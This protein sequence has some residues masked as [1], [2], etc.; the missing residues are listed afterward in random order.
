MKRI[1]ATFAISALTATAFAQI[2]TKE[3]MA[4]ADQLT[5]QAAAA[6]NSGNWKEAVEL[7]KKEIDDRIAQKHA[8]DLIG[9]AY[10][11]QSQN[12]AAGH[13]FDTAI[14]HVN[15]ALTYYMKGQKRKNL[16]SAAYN[17]SAYYYYLRALPGDLDNAISHAE[18]SLKYSDNNVSYVN[19]A[20]QL[21]VYYAD[22][23]RMDDAQKLSKNIFKQGKKAYGDKNVQ[24]AAVLTNQ[25]QVFMRSNNIAQA[26]EYS[27]EAASIYKA[28]G[29]T[30]NVNYATL[31]MSTGTFYSTQEQYET[32]A[33]LLERSRNLLAKTEGE[34]GPNYLKC[35]GHLS[36]AYSN[37]GNLEKSNNIATEM[38][39]ALS[40][41]SGTGDQTVSNALA[42]LNQANV[43]AASGNFQQAIATA[44]PALQ[45]YENFNDEI[46]KANTLSTLAGYY[47]S[48]NQSAKAIE[49]CQ[50]SIDILSNHSG[51]FSELARSYNNMALAQR[52]SGNTS[53]A[54]E[55]AQKSVQNYDAA[56]DTLSTLYCKSLSNLSLFHYENG[57]TAEAIKYVQRCLDIQQKILGK[58]H[59]DNVMPL[60]NLAI[61][62]YQL[63]ENEMMQKYYHEAFTLQSNIVRANF[64]HFSTS[65]RETYWN[66]KKYLYNTSSV[67]ACNS[68]ASDSIIMND[69]YNAQL[70]T[71][72]LLLN[73]EIDFRTLLTRSS[74]AS[75]LEKYNSLAALNRR[76]EECYGT[77]TVEDAAEAERL[78]REYITLERELIRDSKEY[79]DFT[80]NMNI[81]TVDIA[82]H[83]QDGEVAL[84]LF[85]V[86][87]A[88]GGKTFF[89]MYL[90][91]GWTAP[92]IVRMFSTLELDEYRRTFDT[93]DDANSNLPKTFFGMLH[94]K[95]GVNKIFTSEF[96]GK[97]VW[98]E[99]V[100][101][102]G[103]D[104]GL[105]AITDVYFSPT[106]IFH[107]WGIEYLILEGGTRFC[108]KYNVHRLSSTKQLA[109]R[110]PQQRITSATVFGGIQYDI[111]VAEM[112]S[113]HAS[114][115]IDY[116]ASFLS[117]DDE[118]ASTDIAAADTRGFFEM[119]NLGDD[120]SDTNVRAGIGYLPGTLVE[121]ET[122]GEELMMHD[123]PTNMMLGETATEEIF[124]SLSG[125]KQSL[126]HIA[127]HGFSFPET[128]KNRGRLD[129]R[130]GKKWNMTQAEAAM[131]Y[132]GL[133]FA[134]ANNIFGKFTS[135]PKDIENG[136][137]TAAEVATLDLRGLDLLVLSACQTGLGDISE[138]GV[139]G[140]Q[141]GFK[142]A[143]AH[144]IM[145]SLWNVNDDATRILMSSFYKALLG[146]KSRTESLLE[147]QQH[148]R[149][150]G[151]TDPEYWAAFI[152]LDDM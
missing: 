20:N 114:N 127:T 93:E 75:L 100:N 132:S 60:F 54:I 124:K 42:M 84:E 129:E 56:G 16:I 74:D 126:V 46:G 137:L 68:S 133:L 3:Q 41:Q 119:E 5:Q 105:P 35:L 135:I 59:P 31:L 38:Q 40:L 6:R 109:Q 63:G 101:A 125:Q 53:A 58:Q 145:M 136:V 128:S 113:L 32:A 62:H 86:P 104:E 14:E 108:N 12:Y 1:L 29:D 151:Y 37:M 112:K 121:A 122:I 140:L 107:Q 150:A 26:I 90:R 44:T 78:K 95:A 76:I 28:A 7:G 81:T 25:A 34:S 92:R 102:W 118:D 15:T 141:R 4:A 99:I 98:G 97:M 77:Q 30:L 43:L 71:K 33:S 69:V 65:G 66:T 138:E 70:F 18:Q 22:A 47:T 36:A 134:G 8:F 120:D 123:I 146:G 61:Y 143:G 106:G 115:T 94:R 23:G 24:Y 45:I 111:S 50:Q 103:N 64:A 51:R 27:E 144:T 79:G 9:S 10:L 17:H 116:S 49:L 152:L 57:Q 2:A 80:A 142:K 13:E 48:A 117:L 67:F 83:L 88:D 52:A 87:T 131:N 139:F 82:Q 21:I 147:A 89:A 85:E 110:T 96:L 72:G 11:N 73:S 148:V 130:T 149:D 39:N 91:K 19:T 55:F